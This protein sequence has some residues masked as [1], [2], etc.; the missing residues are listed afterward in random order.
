[1]KYADGSDAR[2][3]DRVR[4]ANGDT[5]VIVASMDTNEYSPEYPAENYADLKTGILILTDN[6]ALVRFEEPA[7]SKLLLREFDFYDR[8]AVIAER[9][10]RVDFRRM[11]ALKSL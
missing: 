5:V 10:L 11:A 2:L 3:G 6:G 7:H 9:Q 8:I 4:I 1:M